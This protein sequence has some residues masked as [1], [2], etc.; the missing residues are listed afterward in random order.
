MNFTIEGDFAKQLTV[1]LKKDAAL[2]RAM[3]QEWLS[4]IE[5]NTLHAYL[6]SQDAATEL[7]MQLLQKAPKKTLEDLEKLAK[8]KTPK[9][10]K[11]VGRPRKKASPK[12]RSKR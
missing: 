12:K 3:A 5:L 8:G 9:P 7:L 1:L 10:A 4:K 11:K 2:A 6:V